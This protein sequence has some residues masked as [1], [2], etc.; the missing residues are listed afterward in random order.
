MIESKEELK[1][2]IQKQ[3]DLIAVLEKSYPSDRDSREWL[4]HHT[5]VRDA[6]WRRRMLQ[7]KLEDGSEE[8]LQETAKVY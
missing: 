1:N 4:I 7:T 2:K 6:Y 3:T 5:S 8:D